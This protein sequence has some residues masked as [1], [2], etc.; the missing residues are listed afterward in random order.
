MTLKAVIFDHSTI[1]VS[2]GN[3]PLILGL[4]TLFEHLKSI[5]IKIAVFSTHQI[6]FSDELQRRGF[7]TIDLALTRKDVGVN[8]GSSSWV[9]RAAAKLGVRI[10][11]FL[12]IGDDNRDWRS[13]VNA[14]TFYVHAGW[15][16]PQYDSNVK[17]LTVGNPDSALGLI[18]HFLLPPPRWGC[19]IDDEN[20][21]LCLRCLLPADATLPATNRYS[22]TLQS[23]FTYGDTVLVGGV[24]ALVPLM[25][26]IVSSLYLEGIVETNPLLTVYPSSQPDKSNKSLEPLF[27]LA[28]TFFRGYFRQD[29]LIRGKPALDMSLERVAAKRENRPSQASFLTQ[30]TTV[31]LNPDYEKKLSGRTIVVF[32][33]FTTAGY[34]LEWARNLLYTAGASRVILV[35]AGKYRRYHTIYQPAPETWVTPFQLQEYTSSSFRKIRTCLVETDAQAQAIVERSFSFLVQGKPFPISGL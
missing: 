14:H 3:E 12:Y 33:D 17:Y 10:N 5:G 15:V 2:P 22:F 9:Q 30:A 13:A 35:T 32:D 4:R 6:P 16:R 21:K 11:E 7:P 20:N 24:D 26:H 28:S 1:F 18:S 25:L 8:K 27:R 23:I 31:H 29:L 19:R 34:S